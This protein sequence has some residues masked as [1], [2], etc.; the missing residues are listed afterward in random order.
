MEEGSDEMCV[1]NEYREER[2]RV[3]DEDKN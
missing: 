3:K 1:R 2:K